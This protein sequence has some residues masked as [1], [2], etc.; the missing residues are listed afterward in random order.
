MERKLVSATV[1]FPVD[2]QERAMQ[3]TQLIA[4]PF[5][6]IP[7][8]RE[9]WVEVF[10]ISSGDEFDA[11]KI[12]EAIESRSCEQWP[13]TVQ[14][15]VKNTFVIRRFECKTLSSKKTTKVIPYCGDRW[16]EIEYIPPIFTGGQFRVTANY[17]ARP[18]ANHLY[19]IEMAVEYEDRKYGK[20]PQHGR[21]RP[22]ISVVDVEPQAAASESETMDT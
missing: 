16:I 21:P 4:K 2:S 14:A 13:A 5:P 15:T 9:F 20:L 7:Q 3:F 10:K 8:E 6:S 17:E 22:K 19:E 18:S 11:T 1:Y 12:V